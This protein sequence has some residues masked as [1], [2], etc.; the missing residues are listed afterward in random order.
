MQ[1]L[2][3]RLKLI[4]TSRRRLHLYGVGGVKKSKICGEHT[5]ADR[6]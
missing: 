1:A 4:A 6:G 5:D 3:S 2:V